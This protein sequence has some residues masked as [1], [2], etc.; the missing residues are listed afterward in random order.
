MKKYLSLLIA[1]VI[2]TS[3]LILPIGANA[4]DAASTSEPK[5]SFT[6]VNDDYVYKKAITTLSTLNILNGYE[7]GTFAPFKS[8]TRAEFTKIIVFML[9]YG[10]LSTPITQFDDVPATHWA[11]AHIKVAY[12]L[13]IINGFDEK[14]FAPDSPVTYE[15]ALKMLVC[16]LGYQGDAEIMGGYPVGYQTKASS[17]G[18]TDGISGLSYTANAPRG[19]VAQIMYNALEIEIYEREGNSWV[20]SDKNIL[21]D[22]LNVYALKG[23]VVGIEDSTTADCDTKLYP[24]QMAIDDDKT[25]EEH[26]IDY[27]EYTNSL[28]YISSYLG[29]TV[30]VYYRMDNVDKWLVKIDNETYKNKEMTIY[31]YQIDDYTNHTIKHIPDGAERIAS[32]KLDKDKLTVRYNG[33][34]VSENVILSGTEYEPTDALQEWLNPDSSNFIYGTVKL[35]DSGST[36]KYNIVDIYDYDTIVALKAPTNIDYRITDKTATGTYLTL[37]PD[38]YDYRYVI[39]KNGNQIETTSITANDVISYAKSLDGS[40]YTVQ[41]TAKSVTGKITAVNISGDEKTI[42]I[43]NV[44]YRV[45]DRFIT[46]IETK[47]LKTLTSGVEITAYMDMFGTLEWGTIKVS[48]EFYPYAYVIDALSEGEDYYLKLFAPSNTSSTTFSSST[49]YKVKTFKIVTSGSKFNGKKTDGETIISLLEAS[50]E[51]ANPDVNIANADI[52]LT[53]YNQLI[54][55]KFTSAGE[56]ED[57]VTVDSTI[58][59]GTMNTDATAV[60][61]YKG[62]NADTKYYVT[63]TSVKESADGTTLYSLKSTTPMFVIPKDRTDTDGYSLKSALTGNT[64]YNGGSWY[65]EAYD[66]NDSRYPSCLLVYNSSFKKGT[67]ITDSTVYRLV[68]DSIREELDETEGD[69]FKMLYTFNSTTSVTST[70]ISPDHENL[71]SDIEIG[72]VI[73]NGA[74]GDKH[75]DTLIKVQDFGEISR[76]LGGDLVTVTDAEGNES[77]QLYNWDE[78]QEQTKENS[79]QKYI[80]DF[81]YPK[82]GITQPTDDYYKTGGNTT[83]IYSRAS[84]FNIIQVLTEEKMLY[85]TKSGFTED[86]VLADSSY[87]EIKIS[88]ST[89][90]LRYDEKQK[91]F[92]PYAEGTES[93]ALTAED[94]KDSKNYGQEC[95]KVLITYQ[96][97]SSAKSS[98]PTAKFIVIYD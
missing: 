41:S 81:R 83:N 48:T 35:I 73:L 86:G 2:M 31:S 16:T 27:T 23:I 92:T 20:A 38:D 45:S 56:I 93:T 33:R 14:T 67:S 58:A 95:S 40:Y 75:A 84:M 72:D 30:Q 34:A 52:K 17:L 60:V 50:A 68:A 64:M 91:E 28:A 21:N 5:I 90:I 63:S 80:F 89:K 96:S 43:D 39:T 77:T 1:I 98:A 54:R 22:Y 57:I 13:G 8:I 36:G 18:L 94:L 11:N 6:D 79:W 85:V 74:D 24:G 53:D 49:T 78:T 7:D 65:L 32:T 3:N 10:E 44:E 61:K 62:M 97:S 82:S 66:V 51:N 69:I 37:D 47:E 88:S 9:G 26:I 19:V 29:Q 76:I 42:S 70:K 15:Q 59:E 12:D 87:E 71:F 46:Y 4:A 55:V 25:G